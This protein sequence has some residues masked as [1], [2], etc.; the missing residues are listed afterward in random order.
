MLFRV[1][2]DVFFKFKEAFRSDKSLLFSGLGFLAGFFFFFY[3]QWLQ[4]KTA[5]RNA[6][7]IFTPCPSK[8]LEEKK[9]RSL[10][11]R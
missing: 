10:L 2:Q 3:Y 4:G 11:Q 9:H 1:E 5:H 8:H 6:V 7:S